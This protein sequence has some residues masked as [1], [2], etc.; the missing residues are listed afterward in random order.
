MYYVGLLIINKPKV[1]WDSYF[2]MLYYC[3]SKEDEGDETC[4]L[5]NHY[6]IN[7]IT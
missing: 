3:H 1:A 4:T 2:E 6:N 7:I 5:N